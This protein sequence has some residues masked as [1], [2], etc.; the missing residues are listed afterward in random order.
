MSNKDIDAEN[1][2]VHDTI[3]TMSSFF[4]FDDEEYYDSEESDDQENCEDFYGKMKVHFSS[5]SQTWNTPKYLFDELD[6]L[7][8]FT[9]DVACIESSALCE[10]YF[11]PTDNGLLQD[12]ENNICW[13]NPPY[14]DIITWSKKCVL[15]YRT[16]STVLMLIP[17]RTDTKAFHEYLCLDCTC[18]CFIKG[19]L[20]FSDPTKQTKRTKSNTAPFPSALFVFDDNL[21]QEKLKY[22]QSLGHVMTTMK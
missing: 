2:T 3:D 4:T 5:K 12:W 10:K 22:I 8:N 15:E 13:C 9:L 6:A 21:T 18:I 17:A 1:N 20:C 11:T 16:G 14:D 19:R 7:W